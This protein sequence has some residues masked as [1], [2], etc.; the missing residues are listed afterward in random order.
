MAAAPETVPPV[1]LVSK[2]LPAAEEKEYSVIELCTAAEKVTGYGTVIGSQR[3]GSLWR[4]YCKDINTRTELLTRGLVLR[5]VHCQPKDKN[6][7]VVLSDN[8]QEREV[9]ATRVTVGNIPLSYSNDEIRLAL[10]QLP[11]IKTRS[12]LIDERA[13]DENGKLSHFKT[14]RRF[15]YIDVPKTPLP[16]TLQIGIFMA[17]VFH[18]EQKVVKCSNCLGQGHHSSICTAPVKCRQC[19]ADGHKAGDAAC[20]LTPPSPPPANQ[21]QEENQQTE[22]QSTPTLLP[23]ILRPRRATMQKQISHPHPHHTETGL[24]ALSRKFA[25]H[26]QGKGEEKCTHGFTHARREQRAARLQHER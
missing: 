3:I 1:F 24:T 16:K 2:T 10:E 7:F 17:T 11:D 4:V 20:S 14:G 13:R 22:E 25:A 18:K 8:G 19:L 23:T 9:P 26:Q 15:I 21:H 12:R 5:G 6:P